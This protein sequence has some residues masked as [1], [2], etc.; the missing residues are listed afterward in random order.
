MISALFSGNLG[1]VDDLVISMELLLFIFFLVS[2]YI[3]VHMR[4]YIILRYV[5][6]N[7]E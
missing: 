4:K 3:Q 5:P 2:T 7:H 1:I 6:I